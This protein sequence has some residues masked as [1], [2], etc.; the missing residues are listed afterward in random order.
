MKNTIDIEKGI[1][2]IETSEVSVETQQQE[3][4]DLTCDCVGPVAILGGLSF[5]TSYIAGYL[6][7]EAVHGEQDILPSVAIG[8]MG[9]VAIGATVWQSYE[10]G[11]DSIEL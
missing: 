1:K 9:I 2:Q 8:F 11:Q 6:S 4:H 10:C 5:I 3:S 7:Y